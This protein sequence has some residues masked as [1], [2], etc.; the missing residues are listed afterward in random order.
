LADR[1]VAA[2][3]AAAKQAVRARVWTLLE[4][5]RAA[6][7]PGARGRIPNFIGAEG[8][9]DRLASLPEWQ[10]AR[11]IKANPDAPQL[12]VRAR[13]LAD[14]KRLY[15]AVP[16]LTKERP[17]ILLD[18]RRLRPPMRRAASIKGAA[19][20]GMPVAIGRMEHV[21]VIVCGTVAVNR[22]GVRVGKGGGYSDLEFALLVEAGLVDR[23]TVIAT[24]VHPRQLIAGELPETDHDFRVD[25]I[26][27][28]EEVIRT[29]RMR[30]PKGIVWRDLDNEKLA[31]IPVLRRL[32][33]SLR[34][35]GV[36]VIT[37]RRPD[38][39][40]CAWPSAGSR[41]LA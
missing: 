25:I 17:F 1:T 2:N 22:K 4:R 37:R 12:P 28:P 8:A 31:A 40:R 26:V 23:R 19:A 3:I 15:M 6:R 14:G 33:H 9:A 39:S 34:S 16:R 13:A 30:R 38:P 24:T 27:T 21:D 10:A 11:I 7:F 41:P 36:S 20:T 32:K 5:E 18:P 35:G 29:R